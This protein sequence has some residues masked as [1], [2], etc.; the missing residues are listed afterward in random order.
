MVL[1]HDDW[2]YE[3]QT[4]GQVDSGPTLT[5]EGALTIAGTFS[6]KEGVP[7]MGYAL[8]A[9]PSAEGVRVRCEL[10]K[11]GELKLMR[12]VLLHISPSDGFTGAEQV[13]GR[14]SWHAPIGKVASGPVEALLF[15]LRE[16]RSVS[17]APATFRQAEKDTYGTSKAYRLGLVPSDFDAEETV[18]AEYTISFA[19]MPDSFPGEVTP[20]QE[21]LAIRS[22]TPSADRVGLY[23][24][25]ELDVDLTATHDNPFD[26]EDVA[27]DALVTAP[28][29]RTLT[30]PGFFT[31]DQRREIQD[32]HELMIPEGNGAWKVRF[33]PMEVGRHTYTVRLR[34]KSGEVASEEAS[35]RAVQGRSKG[36]VRQSPVDA[37]YFAHDNGDG[38]LAL[39]H[40]LPIYHTSGQLGDEG[41]RLFAKARENYNRWWM[42]SYGFGLEWM[43]ELGWYRQDAAARIDLVL[44]LAEE[45]GLYYMMCMDTHQDFREGGWERNPFNAKNGGP[46]ETA[47]DWFTDETARALYRKR[48]RYTVA[49]WGYSPNVLCWEFG[50]EFEGWADSPN[51]VKLP[52][53]EEMSEYLASIDP[54][55]HLIST[56]WWGHTGPEEFWRLPSIDIVQ[57]HCYTNDDAN[58]APR[59]R[60]YS[61]H[62]WNTFEKPH[63]FGEF[64][65]RS[66]SS[67]ADKD[68]EGWGI[69]NALWSG[70]F[71]FC[72][73]PPAPWWHEN[74][75]DK[76]DL[77][78]HFTALANFADDLP[79]GTAEWDMMKP[80]D[81]EYLDPDRE[82]DTRDAVVRT[83]QRWGKPAYGRF[84]VLPDGSVEG[85]HEPQ[86]LLHGTGHGDLKNPPTFIV[87]YPHEG[88]FIVKVGVVSNSGHLRVWVDDGLQLDREFPCGEGLGKGSTYREQ[89][90]L[91]ETTYDED[92]VI[93]VPAGLHEIRLENFGDDWMRIGAYTFTDCK[94]LDTPN[95][96]AAG[97]ESEDVAILWLQNLD[98]SWYNHA[99]NGEVNPVDPFTVTLR[100]PSG[101][102]EVEWWDTWLGRP[103]RTE[104]LESTRRRLALE[105]PTLE[106]DVALKLRRVD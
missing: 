10:R 34:D 79:F 95:V 103:L 41:M 102:Y 2:V 47:G 96:L 35:F 100:L 81:I 56:S 36:F 53:H 76:L 87:D 1:W 57:T 29:G 4:G 65:I 91:W 54:W 13:W 40:N 45:L 106:T 67:T 88:Q 15:E 61:L 46:C 30:V 7:A 89:W 23:E 19:D 63:I 72:A 24:R 26:P 92:V 69:H 8:V 70:L 74:Y 78:F 75:I 98:S 37:H 14:P 20:M 104:E 49:R 28:S 12:G 71:S 22:V 80:T 58:V 51:S 33:A 38:F 66:H 5:P 31:L 64:G 9:T 21:P 60:G 48:L 50:N 82:P 97:M 3:T 83:A 11:A 25:L 27:L 85:D 73:G 16:G 68:P 94:V 55:R 43:E 86:Q 77:Y 105:F 18:A 44:D 42:A 6:T 101:S 93:E 52:W 90:D 59:L 99:G 62:Q 39:G 32:G 17:L 84:T